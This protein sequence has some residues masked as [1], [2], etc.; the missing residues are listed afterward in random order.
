MVKRTFAY[1]IGELNYKSLLLTSAKCLVK[2]PAFKP[3]SGEWSQERKWKKANKYLLN[4]LVERVQ[5]ISSSLLNTQT[6]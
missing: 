6:K 4:K 1:H 2:Y 3:E 5:H